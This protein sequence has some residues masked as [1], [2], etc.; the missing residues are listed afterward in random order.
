MRPDSDSLPVEFT[1]W[2]WHKTSVPVFLERFV[3]PLFAAAVVLLAVTNPMGAD[4]T[5]RITGTVALIF[6]AYFVAHTAYKAPRP[7]SEEKI[8][9]S[10]PLTPEFHVINGSVANG[11]KKWIVINNP[12]RVGITDINVE[13]IRY[14]FKEE[15]WKAHKLTLWQFSQLGQLTKISDVPAGQ[16]SQPI[17]LG[18][19]RAVHLYTWAEA[20]Q[21][22]TGQN[23]PE[24]F[25]TYYLLRFTFR[26]ERTKKKLAYYKVTEAFEAS[27][28]FTEEGANPGGGA[29]H[30][31]IYGV[32]DVVKADARFRFGTEVEEY[33]P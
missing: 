19:L 3:L 25:R 22:Q 10:L 9:F 21:Q 30:L 15:D 11:E 20:V 4:R 1:S 29:Q 8:D 6:A 17:E 12:G 26:D 32:P 28:S 14:I 23:I 24:P 27:P 13:G 16:D 33:K 18:K 31:V 2:I 7:P 5:Q